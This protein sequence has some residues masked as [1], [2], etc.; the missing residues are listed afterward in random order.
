MH[1]IGQRAKFRRMCSVPDSVFCGHSQKSAT[2][3]GF[4]LVE[5]LVVV[6]I[7]AILIA[8]AAPSFLVAIRKSRINVR[9]PAIADSDSILM[10]D[11]I[12]R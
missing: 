1:V 3:C 12:T 10:A 8:V 4:T 6:A 5:A 9:I 7:L 11:T 2:P